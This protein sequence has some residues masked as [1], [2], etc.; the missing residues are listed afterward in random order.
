MLTNLK[1][2]MCRKNISAAKIACFLGIRKE[3]M[4]KKVIEKSQ[5][6]RAEMYKI[7]ERFFPDTDF[8]YLFRSDKE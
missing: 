5:F 2:E 4:S 8:H 3:T 7:H 1:V 6:T